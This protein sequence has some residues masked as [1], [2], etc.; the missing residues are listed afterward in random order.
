[1][2]E[3]ID[4]VSPNASLLNVNMDSDDEDEDKWK[5]TLVENFEK[6]INLGPILQNSVSAENIKK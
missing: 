3:I 5:R 1:L 4:S 2:N 6:C